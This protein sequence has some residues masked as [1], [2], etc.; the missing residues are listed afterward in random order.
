MADLIW[1]PVSPLSGDPVD[2]AGAL[3]GADFAKLH[4]IARPLCELCGVPFD[5]P[6]YEGMAC[7]PCSAHAPIWGKARSV[8]VYDDASRGLALTL[9]HAGR[10]DMLAAYGRW[11]ARAGADVLDGA[12]ALIPVPLHASRLRARRFNQSLLLALAVSKVSGV[13]VDAHALA[14]TRRTGT[15][16]GL[17]AKS[18]TRNV[19]GAF[20]VRAMARAR[21]SGQKLVVIDDVHTTGATLSACVRALKR[22]GAANVN[23][24]TLA[25]V[26]KPVSTLK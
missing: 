19:A 9:K 1:P 14:R 7:A 25:R 6:A 24:L 12:D 17:S 10:T 3:T 15:Q 8:L 11:M 16:G 18:R 20:S 23:A 26:V 2:R 13:P 5:Y 4:F 21:V 22:S